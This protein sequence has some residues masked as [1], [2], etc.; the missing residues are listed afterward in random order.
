MLK[1]KQHLMEGEKKRIK[2]RKGKKKVEDRTGVMR[3][4]GT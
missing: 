3:K 1:E 4:S 2:S